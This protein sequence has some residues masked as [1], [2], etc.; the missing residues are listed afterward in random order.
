MCAYGSVTS[1]IKDKEK[2]SKCSH[3]W[4]VNSSGI[5]LTIQDQFLINSYT[6]LNKA[7]MKHNF[8]RL[9]NFIKELALEMLLSFI[10]G[11]PLKFQNLMTIPDIGY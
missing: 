7:N 4:F 6:E 11:K 10:E 1:L 8:S 3:H 5:Q 9:D 2:T